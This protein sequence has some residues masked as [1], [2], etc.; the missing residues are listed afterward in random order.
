MDKIILQKYYIVEHVYKGDYYDPNFIITAAAAELS[1]R[2]VYL[3][4]NGYTVGKYKKIDQTKREVPKPLPDLEYKVN[5]HFLIAIK[6]NFNIDNNKTKLIILKL[7]NKKGFKEEIESSNHLIH[8]GGKYYQEFRKLAFELLKS[9]LNL[10]EN[11]NFEAIKKDRGF[12]SEELEKQFLYSVYIDH[13]KRKFKIPDQ[14]NFILETIIENGF[15]STINFIDVL[16]LNN[17]AYLDYYNCVPYFIPSH[18]Y[19]GCKYTQQPEYK[20]TI[21]ALPIVDYFSKKYFK[22]TIT[23]LPS[24]D[25]EF[26][27]DVYTLTQRRPKLTDKEIAGHLFNGACGKKEV[28]RIK[29]TKR[30]LRALL[31]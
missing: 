25:Y 5:F 3:S 14:Y 19:L 27:N 16:T 8:G 30:R 10:Q 17:L 4:R 20:N 11:K 21:K 2:L 23:D 9:D 15:D 26:Y 28:D 31:A 7:L 24:V 18:N 22:N 6:K 13:L 12:K 1:K 29:Q